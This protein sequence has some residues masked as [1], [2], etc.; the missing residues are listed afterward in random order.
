MNKLYWIVCEE[1]DK[2]LY[3]G[4]FLGRT[5]GAALKHLKEQLGRSNLIGLVFAI[6]EIPVPL[7]RE[8]V[9]EIIAGNTG[10]VPMSET[11]PP[12][13]VEPEADNI[14][15]YEAFGQASEPERETTTQDD[16]PPPSGATGLLVSH[17]HPSGDPAPSSA[18]I[19]ITRRL[20]DASSFLDIPVKDHIIIGHREADPLGIGYYSFS[21]AGLI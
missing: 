11:R 14:V 6:T 4:R 8:I 17:N 20:R 9:A 1:N 5:R 12:A 15:R 21:E 18:D 16:D 7:I 10:D 13:P 19:E 3:E 2:T